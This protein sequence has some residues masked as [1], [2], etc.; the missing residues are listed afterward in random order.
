M[1]QPKFHSVI[2]H[3]F[4]KTSK[5]GVSRSEQESKV[6][7]LVDEASKWSAYA[8]CV[9]P[10][11][12]TFAKEMLRERNNTNVKIATVIGFPDG[13]AVPT[14]QKLEELEEALALGADEIDMVVRVNDIRQKR[15]D[16]FEHDIHAVATKT[17]S[18]VLKLIFESGE[19]SAAEQEHAYARAKNALVSTPSGLRVP[20]FY[21]TST[22]FTP[23]GAD[24]D[25]VARMKKVCGDEIGIKVSGGVSTAEAALRYWKAAGSP[26]DAT[27]HAID[28]MKF[29]IGSSALLSLEG[30]A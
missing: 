2:D 6:R 22:G 28:P 5:E 20:R 29:R 12:I 15:W 18:A 17:G 4:L 25:S 24:E 19:L 30:L 27:T 14:N 8:V 26:W 21:K 9:R 7:Q 11:W 1:R 16:A 3:T 23:H 13:D 10:D